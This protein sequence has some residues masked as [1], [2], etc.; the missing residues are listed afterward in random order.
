MKDFCCLAV[1]GEHALFFL[2]QHKCRN[3]RILLLLQEILNDF[4]HGFH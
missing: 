4:L 1:L 2:S 3:I